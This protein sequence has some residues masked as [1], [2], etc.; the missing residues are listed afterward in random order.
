MNSMSEISWELSIR[1]AVDRRQTRVHF[2]WKPIL[3]SF[4]KMCQR[5]YKSRSALTVTKLE[6]KHEKCRDFVFFGLGSAL[7]QAVSVFSFILV[8]RNSF[9]KLIPI[10]DV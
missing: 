3:N 2:S 10:V 5:V 8:F 6:P 4:K 9:G 7:Y 1:S